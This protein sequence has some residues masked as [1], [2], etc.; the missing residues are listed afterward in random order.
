MY[1]QVGGV[2]R[3]A[4]PKKDPPPKHHCH[5]CGPP[6]LFCLTSLRRHLARIHSTNYKC[7]REDCGKCFKE[8]AQLDAHVQIHRLRECH[9]CGKRFQRKQN[10]DIHLLGV[11]HL[12]KDDLAKLGRW[13]PKKDPDHC[14]EYMTRKA[15]SSFKKFRQK[16]AK[17][18]KKKSEDSEAAEGGSRVVLIVGKEGEAGKIEEESEDEDDEEE[19]E[20]DGPQELIVVADEQTDGGVTMR[21]LEGG[22]SAN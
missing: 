6:K 18:G 10:A 16:Q 3:P 22:M 13:N 2:A 11:H 7:P 9:L 20:I 19:E 21:E 14:P 1:F 15:N 5:L 17:K 8:K 12:T 4:R